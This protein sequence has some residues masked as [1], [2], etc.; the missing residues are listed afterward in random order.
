MQKPTCGDN[1]CALAFSGIL[2]HAE[3]HLSPFNQ[4]R[5]QE[6][7]I[8]TGL[9]KTVWEEVDLSSGEWADY[10]E[11]TQESVSIMEL[12]WKFEAYRPKK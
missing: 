2:D 4:S 7:F 6:N 11:D 10:D 12:S 9:G 1:L 8:A 3:F 5:L